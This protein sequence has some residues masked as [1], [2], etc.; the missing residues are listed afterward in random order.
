LILGNYR[1]TMA[2]RKEPGS[3]SS[4]LGIVEAKWKEIAPEIPF[5]YAFLDQ[6][7]DALFKSEQ[8]LGQMFLVLAILAIIIACMGLLG[9]VAYAAETRT[10]EIGIRKVMGAGSSSIIILLTKE[11]TLL[12]VSS[13][14]VAIPLSWYLVNKWLEN[15]AYKVEVGILPFALAI[16]IAILVAWLTMSVQAI[17]AALMNPVKSIK[18]E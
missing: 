6:K 15:F 5:E 9:L 8:R 14:L 11:I 2:I 4:A 17:K 16:I 10:K 1:T 18:C 12:V 7:F 13:V 3:A